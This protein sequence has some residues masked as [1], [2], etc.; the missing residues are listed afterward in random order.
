MANVYTK[1]GVTDAFKIAQYDKLC[2]LLAAKIG[3]TKLGEHGDL[4]ASV[5]GWEIQDED[6]YIVADIEDWA[7]PLGLS[8]NVEVNT[9]YEQPGFLS[10]EN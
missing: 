4:K 1:E 3:E 7:D 2:E 8:G 5:V 9:E 6:L 10:V